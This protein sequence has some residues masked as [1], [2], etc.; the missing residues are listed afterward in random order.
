[1]LNTECVI[2][3]RNYIAIDECNSVPAGDFEMRSLR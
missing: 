1:M 2:F 3:A